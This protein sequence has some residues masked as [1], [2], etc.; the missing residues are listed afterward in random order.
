MGYA[1]RTDMEDRFGLEE[2]AQRESMLP[3]GAVDRALADA[4]AEIDSYLAGRYQVPVSP[5]PSHVVRVAAAIARYNLLGDAASDRA[6][7]DY[8]DARAWLREVQT[9]RVLLDGAALV[10]AS[11]QRATIDVVT[12]RDK[13]FAGGIQ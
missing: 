9:G 3:V 7:N 13:A 11:A 5:V 8:Q 1:T 6:R 10:T 12:G 2:I 4:D